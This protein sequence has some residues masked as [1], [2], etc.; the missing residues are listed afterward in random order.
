[1]TRNVFSLFKRQISPNYGFKNLAKGNYTHSLLNS[2]E[3]IIFD[4]FDS[5]ASGWWL[6]SRE[7]P[8]PK[9]KEI[10]VDIPYSQ[11]L[12]DFSILNEQRFFSNR[13]LKYKLV[14]SDGDYN[15][16]K[17]KENEAKRALMYAG[18]KTLYDTH[19]PGFVWRAKC[20]E[21]EADDDEK[22]E[23]ITLTV[24][25][26]AYPFAIQ[27]NYEGSDIWDDINFDTW[28][29]QEVKLST[30]INE[31]NNWGNRPVW[32][33]VDCTSEFEITIDDQKVKATPD[34]KEKLL[35]PVGLS[36]V[37]ASGSGTIK[38]KFKCEV[39]L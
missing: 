26:T 20:S 14:L 15:F 25:F 5:I 11:G 38:L 9:E 29:W 2:T 27:R 13:E 39:M 6:E 37:Q 16:R 21:V 1:M 22:E 33:S 12:Q 7:A 31:I 18:F 32:V 10:T 8:T 17:A 34:G 3:G 28:E 24:K 23:T 19:N 36:L 4:Q 30:G 35:L